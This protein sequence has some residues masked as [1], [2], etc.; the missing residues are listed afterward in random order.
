MWETAVAAAG[1]QSIVTAMTRTSTKYKDMSNDQLT[2]ATKAVFLFIKAD[3][4]RYGERQRKVAEDVVLGVD[5]YPNDVDQAYAILNDTHVRQDAARL[6]ST[7]RQGQTNFQR[8]R[9]D[10]VI[11]D[12][13]EVV[14]GTDRRVHTVRCHNCNR[15]GHYAG[16]CPE[17]SSAVRI[18]KSNMNE[19]DTTLINYL[20]DTGSTHNTVNNKSDLYLLTNLFNDK[21][22]HMRSSTGNIMKY[23]EKGVLKP[24][25]IILGICL[26]G[27]PASIDR[28]LSLTVLL[29]L[30]ITDTCSSAAYVIRVAGLIAFSNSW[31][32][33]WL[34][35]CTP[36]ISRPRAVY[37]FISFFTI[38]IICAIDSLEMD[39]ISIYFIRLDSIII[40]LK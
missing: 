38:G 22:L 31:L 21:V 23:T 29:R 4:V 12:G 8:S 7:R 16:Q 40:N 3:P 24:L 9:S 32:K 18:P 30:S 6:R 26:Y 2:E 13:E 25:N 28:I 14:M 33:N 20:L 10:E 5:K 27:N 35:I 15:W 11:P 36:V 37:L 1:E 17:V 39:S 19:Y 34:S